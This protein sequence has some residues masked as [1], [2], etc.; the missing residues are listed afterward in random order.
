MVNTQN[1]H[2]EKV[3]LCGTPEM[4]LELVR[5]IVDELNDEGSAILYEFARTTGTPAFAKWDKTIF[6]GCVVRSRMRSFEHLGP[7]FVNEWQFEIRIHFRLLPGDRSSEKYS[8]RQLSPNELELPASPVPEALRRFMDLYRTRLKELGFMASEGERGTV[9]QEHDS[10][11]ASHLFDQM[12]FHP[13]VVAVGKSLFETRHY[14]QAIFEAFK[15]VNNFAKERANSDLDG[16]QLMAQA[17][18]E[19]NPTICLNEGKTQSDKDEQEGFKFLF[20]GA[21]VGIRNPK[22]H[23]NVSQT[24]PHKTL[25]Y[26]ALASLLMKRIEDGTSRRKP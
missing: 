21:M 4:L 18:D 19:K 2:D 13:K 16:K 15:A 22:A 11:V 20:M 1:K 23:D 26:L 6:A 25:E 5:S 14:A 17:F 9:E 8:V 12:Q 7:S 24:D 3:V 10:K